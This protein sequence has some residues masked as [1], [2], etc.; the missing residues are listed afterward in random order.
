MEREWKAGGEVVHAGESG[1]ESG[2]E[3]V[4]LPWLYGIVVV[5]DT[6]SSSEGVSHEEVGDRLDPVSP[7]GAPFPLRVSLYESCECIYVLNW[8]RY[9]STAWNTE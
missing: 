2:D 3:R 6:Q 8:M 7:T 1:R 5:A 9:A 4:M